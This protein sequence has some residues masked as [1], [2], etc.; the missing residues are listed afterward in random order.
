LGTRCNGQRGG[1]LHHGKASQQILSSIKWRRAAWCRPELKG[2]PFNSG[3]TRL[4]RPFPRNNVVQRFPQ[5][6]LFLI[7]QGHWR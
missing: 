5:Q 2:L 6:N 3:K 4:F 7:R 1:D